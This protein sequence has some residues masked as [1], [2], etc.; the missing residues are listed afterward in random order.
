MNK[1][2]FLI[3]LFFGILASPAHA[4]LTVVTTT[5]D[6]ASLVRE[7]GGSEVSVESI[8]KGSQDPHF[9]EAKPSYMVKLH[10]ADLVIAIGLDL[11]VGWLPGILRGA[12]NPAVMPGSK[13][14]LEVG[15]LASPLE[16]AT[17]KVTRAEGD[18]HPLGNPHVNLDPIRM[19][20]VAIKLA[21]RLGELD[22]AHAEVFSKNAKDFQGRME[23]KTR[24]WSDRIAKSG[25]KEVVT[26][27]RTLTYFLERFGIR[28]SG[29]LEPKPGIPPTSGHILEIIELIRGRKIP[30]ILVENYFDPTVTLKIKQAVA[31]VRSVVVPVAVE[32]DSGVTNT[33]ELIERLIQAV[34]GK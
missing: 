31:G 2:V 7:L 26:Y 6:L 5:P 32:G 14:Y 28:H 20:T 22:P 15:P 1:N 25:V 9:I 19:G 34:E 10:R 18:V 24:A 23:A 29:E 8:A 13:G 33:D 4:K 16:V 3:S 30:L 17:G 11:E 21:E 27:H 12:R